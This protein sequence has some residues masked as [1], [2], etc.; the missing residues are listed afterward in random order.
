MKKSAFIFAATL[1]LLSCGG[2]QEDKT[3][4]ENQVQ[5]PVPNSGP[6]AESERA[7]T[8]T[9]D[10]TD[11]VVKDSVGQGNDLPDSVTGSKPHH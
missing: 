6:E 4:G 1:A 9:M 7:K 5:S 2:E 10:S 3:K 11:D 8:A